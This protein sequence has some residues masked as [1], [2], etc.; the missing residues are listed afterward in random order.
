V[1]NEKM[2]LK[3]LV[4]RPS[5]GKYAYRKGKADQEK[6]LTKIVGL[7]G[8]LYPGLCKRFRQGLL[9]MQTI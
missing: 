5:E 4:L 6:L 3:K 2:D 1:E 9:Q 7:F 8:I